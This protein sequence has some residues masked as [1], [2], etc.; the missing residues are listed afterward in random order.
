MER[1]I[2]HHKSNALIQVLKEDIWNVYADTMIMGKTPQ[3]RDAIENTAK[4]KFRELS[5]P[6]M[7]RKVHILTSKHLPWNHVISINYHPRKS[8]P[9]DSY[10]GHTS[11]LAE[12][13]KV[14]ITGVIEKLES[15]KIGIIPLSCR[16]PENI[17]V[18][19]A[20]AIHRY[21]WPTGL[22]LV[23]YHIEGII[24][25]ALLKF[26]FPKLM[27]KESQKSDDLIRERLLKKRLS[28]PLFFLVDKQDP[29]LFNSALQNL[30]DCLIKGKDDVICMLLRNSWEKAPFILKS[31][32]IER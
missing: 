16:W 4:S 11:N 26:F 24:R 22:D 8:K 28:I 20:C 15:K 6:N 17:A 12:D 13:I 2:Y 9:F 31:T 32:E 25:S 3:L 18:A 7:K 14:I 1:Y 27:K 21:I 19:T 29:S 5:I 30:K 10:S 23:P